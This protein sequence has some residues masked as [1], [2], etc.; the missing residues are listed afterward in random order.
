MSFHRTR[1]VSI[2]VLVLLAA[3]I[4]WQCSN[5][6]SSPAGPANRVAAEK[7]QSVESPATGYPD[8]TIDSARLAQSIRFSSKM[9]K[10]S[11][12]AVAEG[13]IVPGKRKLIRFD[14]ATPNFGTADL[15]FGNPADHLDLYE[16]SPC[17]QHYHL[18]GFSEYRLRN[19][20]GV[21]VTGHKQAP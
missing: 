3:F 17:H 5:E 8:L 16:F 13:C 21:V 11:D 7:N 9:F 2:L 10:S 20:A 6:P 14:V 1:F 18:K 4:G 12:C 19:A 15:V